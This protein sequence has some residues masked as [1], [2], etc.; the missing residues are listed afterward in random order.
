MLAWWFCAEKG[1]ERGAL[2]DGVGWGCD[3]ISMDE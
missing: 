1:E 2:G 3:G